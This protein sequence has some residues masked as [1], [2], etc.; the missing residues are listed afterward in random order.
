[1]LDK[2]FDIE[3]VV[4]GPFRWVQDSLYVPDLGLIVADAN[5]FRLVILDL[6][7]GRFVGECRYPKGWKIYQFE[8]VPDRWRDH[9]LSLAASPTK[10]DHAELDWRL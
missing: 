4:D 7:S 3:M 5:N 10:W 2:H 6:P 1:M 8:A 9:L